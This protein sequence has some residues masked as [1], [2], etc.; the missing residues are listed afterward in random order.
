[1]RLR[2]PE[3]FRR[4]GRDGGEGDDEFSA[5]EEEGRG[6]G[7]ARDRRRSHDDPLAK[8]NLLEDALRSSIATLI[9]LSGPRQTMSPATS[10]FSL[11]ALI[12][13]HQPTPTSTSPHSSN[14]ESS[15]QVHARPRPPPRSFTAVASETFFIEDDEEEDHLKDQISHHEAG[16]WEDAVYKSS[17]SETDTLESMTDDGADDG[18]DDDGT[19]LGPRGSQLGMSIPPASRAARERERSLSDSLSARP[20][21]YSPIQSRSLGSSLPTVTSSWGRRGA[22]RPRQPSDS[23]GPA[24]IEDRRRAR[25]ARTGMN[26]VSSLTDDDNDAFELEH[27]FFELV[28]AASMFMSMSPRHASGSV[29]S[30]GTAIASASTSTTATA[31]LGV[32]SPR[33]T[34]VLSPVSLAHSRSVWT[35][36]PTASP[37]SVPSSDPFLASS[38]PTL[39]L[40][41]GPD[42]LE[43]R[44]PGTKGHARGN[45]GGASGDRGEA[46]SERGRG[47]FGWVSDL[48]LWHLVSIAGLLVGVGFNAA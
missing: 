40:S 45:P 12:N 41:S 30:G 6:R 1:L 44:S 14:Y 43:A 35:P 20:S 22:R 28:D 29:L 4:A 18:S 8:R 39:D 27:T 9:S 26:Q 33:P 5:V 24:S 15:R 19:Q 17:A 10:S 13:P 36:E 38:V 42:E 3:G 31:R 11:N 21:V 47:W 25:A 46:R 16:Q 7:R 23:P 34:G 37:E 48:K 32:A 2:H